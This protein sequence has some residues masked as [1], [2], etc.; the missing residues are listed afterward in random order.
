M[1]L[2]LIPHVN[3]ACTCKVTPNYAALASTNNE[4]GIGVKKN[5]AKESSHFARNCSR[6]SAVRECKVLSF[7]LKRIKSSRFK[8]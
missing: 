1:N 8:Q 2:L 5:F 7:V 4:K 3:V 6:G